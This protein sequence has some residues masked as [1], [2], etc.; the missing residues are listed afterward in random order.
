MQDSR[1]S[2]RFL[3]GRPDRSTSL[4]KPRHKWEDDIKICLQEVGWGVVDWVDLA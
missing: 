4:G 3:V 2:Y 1:G